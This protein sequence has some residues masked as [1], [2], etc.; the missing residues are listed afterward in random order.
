MAS[1]GLL[2]PVFGQISGH[3]RTPIYS[4]LIGGMFAALMALL[5]DLLTLVEMLS[6]GTLIAYTQVALAVLISRYENSDDNN[7]QDLM[8][9]LLALIG[10]IILLCSISIHSFEEHDYIDVKYILVFV[11]LMGLLI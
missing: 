10:I 11:F 5:F 9:T 6:I 4:T 7:N 3:S 2:F 8:Q 1:D